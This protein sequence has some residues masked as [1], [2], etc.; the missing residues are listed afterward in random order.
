[1]MLAVMMLTTSCSK[2]DDGMSAEDFAKAICANGWQGYNQY[3]YKEMGSWVD[4]NND[5]VVIRFDRAN[6]TDIKGTGRQLQF[7]NSNFS[8]LQE[9]S[10]FDWYISDGRI[11]ITYKADW[12]RVNAIVNDVTIK[13]GYFEGFWLTSEADRRYRFA[14]KVSDFK[15]WDKYPSK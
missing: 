12:G 15:D 6:A 14:Y 9:Q 4:R 8:N 7:D 11:Y 13:G 3:Q 1:M 5:F 10:D 2:S